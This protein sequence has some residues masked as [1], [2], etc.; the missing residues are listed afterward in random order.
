MI[1]ESNHH[2]SGCDKKLFQLGACPASDYNAGV[3][4]NPLRGNNNVKEPTA[5]FLPCKGEAYTYEGDVAALS[6]GKCQ[7]GLMRCV[8]LPNGR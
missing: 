6:N 7:T 1:N 3:C 4:R 2:L 8:I 5:F